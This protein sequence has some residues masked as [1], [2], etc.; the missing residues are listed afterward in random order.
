MEIGKGFAKDTSV[1]MFN[2]KIK[3]VQNIAV[4]DVVMGDDSTPRTVLTIGQG[5]GDMY[6]ITHKNGCSYTVA[7]GNVLCLRYG[8]NKRIQPIPNRNVYR[9]FYFDNQ[10]IKIRTKSFSYNIN[11]SRE[12]VLN[13]A[14]EYFNSIEE[15]RNCEI[16]VEEYLE[17]YKSLAKNLDGYSSRGVSFLQD[18]D[19][20][21]EVDF[22]PYII[23]YW[24]GDG[25]ACT[26]DITTQDSAVLKYVVTTLPKFNCYLQFSR[27]MKYRINGIHPHGNFF[28]R[29]LQKHDMIRKSSIPQAL[30]EQKKHIPQVYKYNSREVRL[31]LLAGI[32]DS[33]GY[34]DK[35]EYEICQTIKHEKLVLDMIFLIKSLGFRCSSIIR[36]TS[37]TYKGE[38][39]TRPS[40][41]IRF[42]GYGIEELPVKIIRKKAVPRKR[43]TD[44]LMSGITVEPKGEG[45]FYGFT[46]DG[47]GKLIFGNFVVGHAG[48]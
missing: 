32:I 33:D 18:V 9:I 4:G 17:L 42:S 15:D 40:Y 36:N 1:L 46:V 38:R 25:T 3:Y 44:A 22:D 8:R 48:Q 47:N 10:E 7:G 12:T 16:S 21:P 41:R 39:R 19:F 6:K 28:L 23:G 31:A 20:D 43:I 26:S 29:V 45:D 14:T 5:R 11:N 24:L 2:G 37:Y 35:G 30:Q 34:L 13:K 27:K